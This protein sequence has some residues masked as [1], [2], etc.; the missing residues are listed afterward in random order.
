MKVD[1]YLN[2]PGHCEEAFRFYEKHLG[3][4]VTS[5]MRH[6]EI[7]GNPNIPADWSRKILHARMELGG[8]ELMAADIPKAQ[9]MRSAYLTMRFDTSKEADTIYALLTSGG[10]I[11]MKMDETFFAHRFAMVRDKFGTSWMLLHEKEMS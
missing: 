3:G 7:P 11:L 1:I 2:Y 4:K 5:M 9:P 8:I 10:E 6:G